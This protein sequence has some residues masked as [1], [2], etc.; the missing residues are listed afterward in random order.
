[1]TATKMPTLLALAAVAVVTFFS[2]V[3]GALAL[4]DEVSQDERVTTRQLGD[5]RSI[6]LT[7]DE[8]DVELRTLPAGRPATLQVVEEHG[9]FGGPDVNVRDEGGR[10]QADSDCTAFVFGNSCSTRWILSVPRGTPVKVR[11][12]SGD[13][14]LDG[15]VGTTDIRTGSGDVDVRGAEGSSMKVDT[16]SGDIT[17]AGV[18][19]RDLD[20][21]TGSGDVELPG[22]T[23]AT[24]R[25]DA[26]SGDIDVRA[27]AP[28][29]SL[30]AETGSGDIALRV[31]GGPY[32]VS[33]RTGSGDEDVRVPTDPLA[34]RT[35]R[36]K[37][38]SGDVEVTGR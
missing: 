29:T 15:T 3:V 10:I 33:T 32:A 34:A 12:G 20:L 23:A 11:T 27:A 6:D 37:T 24:V 31:P 26:S 28:L 2:V 30:T 7:S 13:V 19:V 5:V 36:L 35:L 21:R 8:G 25:L 18:R 4:L 16:G 22:L 1:M 17:A 9:L 38:G 14:E